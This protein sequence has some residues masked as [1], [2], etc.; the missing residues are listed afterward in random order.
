MH[1]R[2]ADPISPRLPLQAGWTAWGASSGRPACCWR[3]PACAVPQR[4]PTSRPATC[5]PLLPPLLSARLSAGGLAR[6]CRG[7][8]TARLDL[9][10]ACRRHAAG[11]VATAQRRVCDAAN[12]ASPSV[13]TAAAALS[14]QICCMG[15]ARL[16]TPPAVYSLC[17]TAAGSPPPPPS[18]CRT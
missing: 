7:W 17:P 11:T 18:P 8:H 14:P 10:S 15:P 12:R 9:R 4:R 13:Q 5:Q 6:P 1:V 2:S 16:S 3:R